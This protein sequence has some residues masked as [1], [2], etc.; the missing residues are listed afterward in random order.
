MQSLSTPSNLTLNTKQIPVTHSDPFYSYMADNRRHEIPKRELRRAGRISAG[1][2]GESLSGFGIGT[3]L[4]DTISS[5]T[6]SLFS[7][8][9]GWE[10]DKT[11]HRKVP[12]RL[13]MPIVLVDDLNRGKE[14]HTARMIINN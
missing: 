8:G 7:C 14:A 13:F 12:G 3:Y 2:F 6:F 1:F 4:R 11:T 9:K 10:K 5:E